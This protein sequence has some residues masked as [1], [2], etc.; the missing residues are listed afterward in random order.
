MESLNAWG[1]GWASFMGR[2]LVN[3]SVL[4]AVVV[5]IW[6]PLRRRMSAQ[7]A[8]GLFL[9]VLLKLAVPIP[10]SWPSW[11]ADA[12]LRRAASGLSA[13]AIAEDARA[14]RRPRSRRT[15]R[16]WSPRSPSRSSP[17]P[18]EPAPAPARPEPPGPDCP[19]EGS[20]AALDAR[21]S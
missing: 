1:A 20:G 9:L 16:S 13:W 5:L 15:S 3:S 8:H 7:F 17:P 2:A 11:S 10:A 21:P 18:S 19:D 6:L 14:R 12:S 4:L